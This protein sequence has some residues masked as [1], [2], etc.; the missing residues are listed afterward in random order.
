MVGYIV[1]V[2]LGVFFHRQIGAPLYLPPP[3]ETRAD[4]KALVLPRFILV[5][6]EWL[7]GSWADQTH[8]APQDVDQLW[9]LVDTGTAEKLA[10]TCD[11]WIVG[12]LV[13][14]A[15]VGTVKDLL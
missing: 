13:S 6:N 7:L 1:D 12:R 10:E 14:C 8:V 2:E 11:T 15:A 9:Q 5:D 4:K 3:R